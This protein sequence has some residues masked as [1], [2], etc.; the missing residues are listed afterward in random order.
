MRPVETASLSTVSQTTSMALPGGACEANTSLPQQE[1]PTTK[2]ISNQFIEHLLF[3]CL[4]SL[5]LLSARS[6]TECFFAAEA[7]CAKS[8][9]GFGFHTFLR[10]RP[11]GSPGSGSTSWLRALSP[12][13]LLLNPSM[14]GMQLQANPQARPST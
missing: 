12:G 8:V 6:V 11:Q 9:Q 4:G 3:T 5:C 10:Q 7:F 14:W 2:P 1:D 13:P